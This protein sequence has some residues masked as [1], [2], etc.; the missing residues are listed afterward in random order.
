MQL[1]NTTSGHRNHELGIGWCAAALSLVL[2]TAAGCAVNVKKPLTNSTAVTFSQPGFWLEPGSKLYWRSDL[3]YIFDEP[4]KNSENTRPFLQQET[5]SWLESRTY[6][7]V[8][9]NSLTNYGLMAVVVLGNE[10]T[11]LEIMQR[12]DLTPSFNATSGVPT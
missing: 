3:V 12:F 10:V 2:L 8:E 11:A 6:E 1:I 9:D 4:G 5:Q 7:F